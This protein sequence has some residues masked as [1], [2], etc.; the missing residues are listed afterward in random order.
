[1]TAVTK[2]ILCN[3]GLFLLLA[4]V[5]LPSACGL[6]LDTCVTSFKDFEKAAIANVSNAEALVKAFYRA[7]SPFPQSVQVV[8]HVNSSNGTDTVISTDP[9]CPTGEEVWL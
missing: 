3:L 5:L 8:Y 7:N 6:A 2:M 4:F 9:N 1:M